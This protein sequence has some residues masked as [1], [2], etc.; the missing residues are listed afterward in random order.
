M[1]VAASGK[2]MR[3]TIEALAPREAVLP[4]IGLAAVTLLVN[5]LAAASTAD[6]ILAL[7]DA[8]L[9]GSGLKV[10]QHRHRG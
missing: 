5:F 6:Q 7:I 4:T 1:T 8:T 2:A 9:A 3:E 10:V